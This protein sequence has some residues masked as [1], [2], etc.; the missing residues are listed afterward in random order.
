MK[1]L[2]WRAVRKANK[3]L[4]RKRKSK[5]NIMSFDVGNSAIKF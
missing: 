1:S 3:R 2:R 5:I 4:M